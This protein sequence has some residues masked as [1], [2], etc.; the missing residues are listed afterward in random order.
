VPPRQD[1]NNKEAENKFK[2]ISEA[3]K[4]SNLSEEIHGGF[5]SLSGRV[6]QCSDAPLMPRAATGPERS[7]EARGVR[8]VRRGGAQGA[9][10]ADGAGPGGATFSTGGDGPTMF[11][12][13]P[14]NVEDIFAEFLGGSSPFGGMGGG[15]GGMGGGMPAM[16]TGGPR[17]SLGTIYSARRSAAAP[18]GTACTPAGGR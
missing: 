10:A 2:Q 8:P 5:I 1:P 15:G 14:R 7:S 17:P 12:F 11:R 9:S 18:T 6:R 4:V 3:Y 16:R 13:N